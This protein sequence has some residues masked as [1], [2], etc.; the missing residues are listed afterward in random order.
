MLSSIIY[1]WV[2]LDALAGAFRLFALDMGLVW[3]YCRNVMPGNVHNLDV[4]HVKPVFLHA[5]MVL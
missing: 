2:V 1:M 3:D 4:V 5:V